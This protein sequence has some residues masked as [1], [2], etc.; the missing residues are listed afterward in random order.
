MLPR[1]D[2]GGYWKPGSSYYSCGGRHFEDVWRFRVF[3]VP[4]LRFRAL[5]SHSIGFRI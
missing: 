3:G 2:L 5:G 4:G 1:G